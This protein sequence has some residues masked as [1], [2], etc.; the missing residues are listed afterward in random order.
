LSSDD[1]VDFEHW[2]IRLL[3][4]KLV[5]YLILHLAERGL[6]HL[7]AWWGARQGWEEF[8]D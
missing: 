4:L 1:Q 7:L 6:F 8:R 3:V 5:K 2:A